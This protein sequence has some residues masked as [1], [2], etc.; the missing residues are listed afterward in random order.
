[1]I[2]KITAI[3]VDQGLFN[4]FKLTNFL[5]DNLISIDLIKGKN[6]VRLF[7]QYEPIFNEEK[8]KQANT[9]I[10]PLNQETIDQD[11]EQI[12]R[13]CSELKDQNYEIDM[14]SLESIENQESLNVNEEMDS[15]ENDQNIEQLS[16]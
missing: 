8:F 16:K 15:N 1:M 13:F 11:T 9:E 12:N 7:G 14:V 6:M 2:K 4:E 5:F 10:P 3:T